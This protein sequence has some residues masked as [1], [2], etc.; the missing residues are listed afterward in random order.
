MHNCF[1]MLKR[2]FLLSLCIFYLLYAYLLV[3]CCKISKNQ[4]KTYICPIFLLEFLLIFFFKVFSDLSP[5]LGFT[6]IQYFYQLLSKAIVYFSC[7]LQKNIVSSN[8]NFLY[9]VFC[10]S[11]LFSVSF[12]LNFFI[13]SNMVFILSLK[14]LLACLIPKPSLTTHLTTH[15]F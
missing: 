9:F 7:Y 8:S 2:F 1:E 12:F 3:V 11:L 10:F 6:T 13:Q 15:A 5:T 4:C 14:T